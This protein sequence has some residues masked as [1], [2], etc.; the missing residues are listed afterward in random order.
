MTV[1]HGLEG[2]AGCWGSARLAMGR[3]GEPLGQ[4]VVRGSDSPTHIIRMSGLI[5]W[6]RG[7]PHFLR[8]KNAGSTPHQAQTPESGVTCG[9]TGPKLKRVREDL[10]AA[11]SCWPET[12]ETIPASQECGERQALGRLPG[13]PASPDLSPSEN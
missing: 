6:A 8:F 11:W 12:A 13:L 5:F 2:L 7:A 3:Q 1:C 10:N 4:G 9:L